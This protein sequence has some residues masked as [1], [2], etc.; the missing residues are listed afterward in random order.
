MKRLIVRFLGSKPFHL[1]GN[2]PLLQS[3]KIT[4]SSR[5]NKDDFNFPISPNDMPRS[6]GIASMMRLPV[7]SNAEGLDACFVGIP[8]DSG[9][10]N[11]SGTRLGPR[12]IRAESC[13]IRPYNNV[14]GAAPF[15]SL[16]IADIGDIP[17]NTYSLAA[18][19]DIIRRHIAAIANLGCKPLILGGDHTITYPILQ[20]IKEKHGPVGLV[21]V[22]AH[23]DTSDS[24]FGEKVTHGTPFRRAVEEGLLDCKR[25][26]QI[27]LRG[28]GYTGK[29]YQWA[30]DQ[31]FRLV[32]AH[33][34]WHKSLVPLMAEVRQQ[35]G[36]GPVY[37][38]FDID[39]LDPAFAPGTGTPEI[40]GLTSI[41][42]IEILRGCRGMNVVGGDMVE[43]SPP[44]DTTGTTALTAANLLFEMLCVLP[45]V[46]YK[47]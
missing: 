35:M 44:Y 39:G 12:Q 22:D 25:V 42:G 26:V 9:T 40:G 30:E 32:L 6:G 19:V 34:C 45:G 14:T 31:G 4:I 29:D 17:I 23:S 8:L 28:S 15:E 10:S 43:V 24:M 18:T 2:K 27:G 20:G 41:Q 38:S 5:L 13:M 16:M 46:K 36:S 47:P 21:H 3:R 1:I 7:P 33:E 11:R 37:I